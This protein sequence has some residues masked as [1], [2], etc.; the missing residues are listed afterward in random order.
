MA[1]PTPITRNF[2]TIID[3]G[4][5]TSGKFVNGT[6]YHGPP[7]NFHCPRSLFEFIGSCGSLYVAKYIMFL[8]MFSFVFCTIGFWFAEWL[9]VRTLLKCES[10]EERLEM[11]WKWKKGVR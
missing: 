6:E 8:I 4:V 3:S 9:L 2:N 10:N 7:A 1:L 5:R 11:L